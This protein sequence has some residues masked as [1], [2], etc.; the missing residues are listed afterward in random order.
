MGLA[1]MYVTVTYPCM[2]GHDAQPQ[3]GS[4]PPL[5]GENLRNRQPVELQPGR[6]RQIE[7][8]PQFLVHRR[9]DVLGIA[10][11]AGREATFGIGGA[12]HQAPAHDCERSDAVRVG[13][14]A[15]A[16]VEVEPACERAVA[17]AANC[18]AEA[19]SGAS[20]RGRQSSA[21]SGQGRFSPRV[22]DTGGIWGV[23]SVNVLGPAWI[24]VG[25]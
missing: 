19:Q 11:I 5:A 15:I 23:P 13:I 25:I 17:V 8:Q 16:T 2:Y 4:A 21:V 10:F 24:L 22:A 12:D 1:G 14:V 18:E 9:H 3:V 7:R 6:Q 20:G